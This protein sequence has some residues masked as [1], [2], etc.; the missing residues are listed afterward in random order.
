MTEGLYDE[1]TISIWRKVMRLHD[2]RTSWRKDNM[3][4]WLYGGKF[5]WR[6]DGKIDV[7]TERLHD[8]M[9]EGLY[10]GR[11]EGTKVGRKEGRREEKK[12][13]WR[14]GGKQVKP[15]QTQ[16]RGRK[17]WST[18]WQKEGRMTWRKGEGREDCIKKGREGGRESKRIMTKNVLGERR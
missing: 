11:M 10:H 15:E 7:R 13:Y 8:Y 9:T 6:K 4:E 2:G 3:M 1:R 12:S 18:I 14:K 17:K 5:I 16:E